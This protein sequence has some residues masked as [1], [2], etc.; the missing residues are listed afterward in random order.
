MDTHSLEQLQ[1]SSRAC[2]NGHVC[3]VTEVGRRA[4]VGEQ[5]TLGVTN[6]MQDCTSCTP[7]WTGTDTNTNMRSIHS[8]TNKMYT[9]TQLH[10]KRQTEHTH[11]HTPPMLNVPQ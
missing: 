5:G 9:G 6:K 7:L 3:G 4:D 8:P 1:V 2:V 10:S 11:T